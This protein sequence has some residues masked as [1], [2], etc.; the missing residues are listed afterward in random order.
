M[1]IDRVKILAKI[2]ALMAKTTE[3]GCTEAEAMSALEKAR[4]MMDAYEVT[5]A[6][7]ELKGESAQV[8]ASMARDPHKVRASLAMAIARFCDCKCW[9][10][11]DGAIKFC[12]LESDADLAG[13]LLET[14]ARFV[15]RELV[16]HL[17]VTGAAKGARRLI[18]SGFTLGCC[19]RINQRLGEMVTRSQAAASTN[20]RALVVAKGALVAAKMAEL[21]LNLRSRRSR[22]RRVDPSA[23]SAGRAA[24][25]RA[26]F[27]RPVAGAG[28]Q[29]RIA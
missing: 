26:S 6:D 20:G 10:S 3:N 11:S 9:K 1:Q 27:G 8:F 2:R 29:R 12:G 28:G 18:I 17:T 25:D 4:E 15:E 13:W 23:Y 14:L 19:N 21:G 24:G 16:A 7:V 22:G 5:A